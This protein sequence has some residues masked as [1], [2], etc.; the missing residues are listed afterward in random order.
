MLLSVAW[1]RDEFK[2]VLVGYI[3]KVGVAIWE[4]DC[5]ELPS[6]WSGGRRGKGR[7]HDLIIILQKLRG[8]LMPSSVIRRTSF[9]R[10]KNED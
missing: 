2:W 4:E 7:G 10:F 9:F 5:G 3:V 1:G 6:A 8:I